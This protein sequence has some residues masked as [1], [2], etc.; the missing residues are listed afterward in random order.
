MGGNCWPAFV[1]EMF[2]NHRV[3]L[4]WVLPH[5]FVLKLLS[6]LSTFAKID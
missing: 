6:S 5:F 1:E 4:L 3:I 2:F